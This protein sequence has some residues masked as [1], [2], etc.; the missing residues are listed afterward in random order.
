MEAKAHEKQMKR[1]G[2]NYFCCGHTHSSKGKSFHPANH[3]YVLGCDQLFKKQANVSSQQTK[4]SGS[5]HIHSTLP[6]LSDIDHIYLSLFL[7]QHLGVVNRP[8][9]FYCLSF[10]IA[11]PKGT[12]PHFT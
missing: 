8:S 1:H 4:T 2:L 11:K 12:K 6:R 10:V 5:S 3:N 9:R 7:D